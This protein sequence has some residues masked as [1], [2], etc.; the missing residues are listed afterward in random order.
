MA[1][2]KINQETCKAC[3]LCIAA[4]PKKCIT[5]TQEPNKK[6]FHPASFIKKDECLGCGFC[7]AVC[8]DICIEVYK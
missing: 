6:G 3:G 5:F 4:C 7:Y 8:P 1:E 2:I